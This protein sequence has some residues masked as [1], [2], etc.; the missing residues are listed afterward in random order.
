MK[1]SNFTKYVAI[2]AV[3]ATSVGAVT[4]GADA[5]EPT[6]PTRVVRYNDL[7]L[8]KPTDV[9]VLYKRIQSAAEQVCGD[10]HSRQLA[11]A[12]AAKAC[13][14]EAVYASFHSMNNV[15]MA[16]EYDL[17]VASLR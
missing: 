10:A 1:T 6:A 3:A 8:N 13:V 4:T 7:N 16:Q 11:E 12:M 15:K 5:A 17:H 2:A 9:A 14:R